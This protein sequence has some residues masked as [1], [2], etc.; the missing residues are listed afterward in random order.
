MSFDREEVLKEHLR[1]GERLLWH[2]RPCDRF[3]LRNIPLLALP[4][5]WVGGLL[6]GGVGIALLRVWFNPDNWRSA[7]FALSMARFSMLPFGIIFFLI[8]CYI[9]GGPFLQRIF[10]RATFY[11]ITDRRV[12]MV[13]G[14]LLRRVLSRD[15]TQIT[16]ARIISETFDGAGDIELG[17]DVL[18][19]SNFDFEFVENAGEAYSILQMA[20]GEA[21]MRPIPAFIEGDAPRTLARTVIPAHYLAITF[22][23][24]FAVLDLLAIFRTRGKI[25]T[26]WANRQETG[27]LPPATVFLV[28]PVMIYFFYSRLKKYQAG[29]RVARTSEALILAAFVIA[30]GIVLLW[31]GLMEVPRSVAY[32]VFGIFALFLSRGRQT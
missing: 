10:R 19:S 12:I 22:Y 27:D 26:T 29:A 23:V 5:T 15:L 20:R 7:T 3:D 4:L 9:T 28:V 16:F 11:A 24:L 2:G 31:G 32:L 17:F 18:T 1:P 6:F 13:R 30:G 8:G 21:A 14:W 25:L